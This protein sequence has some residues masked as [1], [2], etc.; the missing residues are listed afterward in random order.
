MGMPILSSRVWNQCRACH[1]AEQEQNRV[2][3]HLVGIV[4][5][6]IASIDGFRYSSALQEL[7]GNQW[8]PEELDAW[9][10]NPR[11]YASGT[12][13]S[14]PGVKD[15]GDRANLLAYLYSLQN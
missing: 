1:V 14:Y 5:R 4:G 8:T 6:D 3:P 12:S 10:L 7:Q 9:L 15:D 13:M 2:G 11:E